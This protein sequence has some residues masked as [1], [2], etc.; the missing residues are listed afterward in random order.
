M[1]CLVQYIDK[2]LCVI[3]RKANNSVIH[4]L[5]R[6]GGLNQGGEFI[7]DK[8]ALEQSSKCWTV[9]VKKEGLGS[10]QRSMSDRRMRGQFLPFSDT[11]VIRAS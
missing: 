6:E 10:D 2:S 8:L 3:I 1:T 5:G 7:R 4:I 9:A 11:G